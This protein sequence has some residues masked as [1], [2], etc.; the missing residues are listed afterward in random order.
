[1]KEGSNSLKITM[2]SVP[3]GDTNTSKFSLDLSYFTVSGTETSLGWVR[4]WLNEAHN[5]IEEIFE[6]V[7]LTNFE[8]VFNKVTD[9]CSS[10]PRRP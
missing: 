6:S 3:S 9:Q 8:N 5:E 10:N 7:S 1:M 4:D 2:Q